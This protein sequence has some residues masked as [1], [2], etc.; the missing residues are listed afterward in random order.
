MSATLIATIAGLTAALAWGTGDYLSARATRKLRPIEISLATESITILVGIALYLTDGLHIQTTTQLLHIV[1]YSICLNT[2][3]LIFLKALSVGAVGIVAPI[4]NAYPFFTLLL[5]LGFGQAHFN[6]AEL[7]ALLAIIVGAVVLAYEKNH[8]KIPLKELHHKTILASVAAL[9]W[10]VGFFIL[11]PVV[12]QLH[13]Q[14]VAIVSE[15]CSV[16]W[17]S[18][19]FAATT[20]R[21][22]WVKSVTT[23]FRSKIAFGA[24][25]TGQVGMLAFYFGSGRASNVVIPTVLSGCGTLIASLWSRALDHERIGLIRRVGALLVVAGIIVLNLA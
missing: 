8:K 3:F 23:A 4:G 6:L 25:I 18:S 17:V 1:A 7:V 22:D 12:D 16:I 2:A 10:G 14:S 11:N 13:W 5:A 19:V 20:Q 24:G 15:I 21:T 9:I